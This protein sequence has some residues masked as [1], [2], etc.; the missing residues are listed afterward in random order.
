MNFRKEAQK[1][2]LFGL[3]LKGKGGKY[4]LEFES[5][6][7]R[8]EWIKGFRFLGSTELAER[9]KGLFASRNEDEG[10]VGRPKKSNMEAVSGGA[11][12]GGG[13]GGASAS[14]TSTGS[15]FSSNDPASLRNAQL[16]T[17]PTHLSP[18]M[19]VDPEHF[20]RDISKVEIVTKIGK[21]QFGQVFLVKL[22]GNYL[23][24]KKF[25]DVETHGDMELAAQIIREF[26]NEAGIMASLNHPNI[27]TFCGASI[28]MKS[29]IFFSFFFLNK[30][31]KK[32]NLDLAI[33]V[34]YMN[35]GSLYDIIHKKVVKLTFKQKIQILRDI[36][37]GLVSSFPPVFLPV[38]KLTLLSTKKKYRPIFTLNLSSIAI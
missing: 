18:N 29:L 17:I 20:Q 4:L 35:K 32:K 37:D 8:E 9:K 5:E 30:K 27:I 23:A 11:T 1:D 16:S 34:E 19:R 10:E 33:L 25:S 15:S 36:A 38:F 12:G 21:G 22:D 31:K 6:Q 14:G 7:Q 3:K 28:D 26:K 24:M 13:G 2:G